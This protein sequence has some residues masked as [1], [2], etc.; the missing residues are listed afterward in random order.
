MLPKAKPQLLL[1]WGRGCPYKYLLLTAVADIAI[2]DTIIDIGAFT[3][4]I[5][6]MANITIYL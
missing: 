4:D 5:V 1:K 3:G 6:D 2:T